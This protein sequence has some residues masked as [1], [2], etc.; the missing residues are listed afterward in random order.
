[1]VKLFFFA[2]CRIFERSFARWQS[3]PVCAVDESVG[4][5]DFEILAN[6]NLRGFEMAR[7][8]SN[9]HSSLMVQEVENGATAFFV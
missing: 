4:M 3:A 5:Q 6:R 1:M 9:Q 2:Q 7:E 8:F